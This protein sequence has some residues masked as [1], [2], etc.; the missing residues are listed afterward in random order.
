MGS[1]S[2]RGRIPSWLVIVDPVTNFPVAPPLSSVLPH[3]L[4][5][6][7]CVNLEILLN[8]LLLGPKLT[9][10]LIYNNRRCYRPFSSLP[11]CSLVV[12]HDSMR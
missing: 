2:W 11:V 9:I 5:L 6:K 8:P 4:L 1:S 12:V 10:D 7:R 3:G